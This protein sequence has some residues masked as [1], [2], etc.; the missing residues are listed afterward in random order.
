ML[1]PPLLSLFLNTK[2]KIL[3]IRIF[4][5][6]VPPSCF[7]YTLLH[8]HRVLPVLL[9]SC[10]CPFVFLALSLSLSLSLSLFLYRRQ[11]AFNLLAPFVVIVL[12]G[13]VRGAARRGAAQGRG[14]SV[15]SSVTALGCAVGRVT[16]A[17]TSRFKRLAVRR[18]RCHWR[19]LL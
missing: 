9:S 17:R 7:D 8:S 19:P 15:H 1:W 2:A 13:L 14:K 11:R 16:R 5:G 4:P 6:G 18:R 10:R 3:L 12:L